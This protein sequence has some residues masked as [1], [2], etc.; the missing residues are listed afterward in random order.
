MS[1]ERFPSLPFEEDAAAPRASDATTALDALSSVEFEALQWVVRLGDEPGAG[2]RLAFEGWLAADDRHREA[3]VAMQADVDSVGAD[4]AALPPEMTARL[5]GSGAAG[6][7][8]DGEPGLAPDSAPVASAAAGV[9]SAGIGS[10]GVASAGVGSAGVASAGVVLPGVASP[11]VLSPGVVCPG[12]AS[13]RG[14][15]PARAPPAARSPTPLRRHLAGVLAVALGSLLIGGVGFGWWHWQSQPLFND[16]FSTRRGQQRE[17]AL[18]DGSRL[19]LDT[20]T[21]AEVALYRHRREVRLPEGQVLF[22]VTADAGKPFDVLAGA[23]RVRVIGTRFSV[24]YAPSLGSEAV[25]VAVLEGQVSVAPRG[26]D[27]APKS[28]PPSAGETP[29]N[30]RPVDLHPGQVYRS[31]DRGGSGTVITAPIVS[32]AAWRHHR[33]VFEAAPLAAVL[34]EID[35]YQPSGIRLR[36]AAAGELSVTASVDLREI[37]AFI[38]SLPLVLPIRVSAEADGSQVISLR[39]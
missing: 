32:M 6:L 16:Q 33:L 22:E 2:D 31:D 20:A 24:R 29:A 34:A 23:T 15:G 39:P 17:A 25:E 13:P 27:A 10:A 1:T 4:C 37:R 9:G 12:G 11:G 30:R 3:F 18:P 26:P 35:R 28:G 5:R 38:R 14:A 21:V 36:D 7:A 19:V 8:S